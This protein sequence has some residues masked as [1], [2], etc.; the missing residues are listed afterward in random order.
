MDGAHSTPAPPPPFPP[1]P[2]GSSA[3]SSLFISFLVLGQ[4]ILDKN[5]PQIKTVVNKINAI[6]ETYRFFKMELLA[7]ED[8]MMATVKEH[9][10]TFSFDFSKVYWNSRLQSE[11]KRLVNTF[12]KDDIICD[13]FAGVGP[14]AIPA[15]KKGCVVYAND[16]NPD[17]Y[18]A[19]LRNCKINHVAKNVHCFNQDAREFLRHLLE[20]NKEL[21]LDHVIMN[22]PATAVNF[23]DAFRGVYRVVKP[24]KTE[25]DVADDMVKL[26]RVHCYCFSKAED[27]VVDAL[28]QVLS[29]L[30]L[31]KLK[32]HIVH[33]V[34]NV[35]PKKVML[36]VSFDLPR[37]VA[38]AE[39][40][41]GPSRK[42]GQRQEGE[43]NSDQ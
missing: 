3:F 28:N 18:A 4:V 14:F 31:T 6:D 38:F 2:N 42:R 23:L 10:C 27:T 15:A 19:L 17:S 34:R 16:L 7:G 25:V 37:E 40:D 11:H 29:R 12:Q 1:L 32:S 41:D 20:K 39:E 22:L 21:S 43:F 33:I 5:S 13:M 8:N 24:N 9:G 36:C 30:G 26:P 35:A